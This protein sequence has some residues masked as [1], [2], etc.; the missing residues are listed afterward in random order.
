MEEGNR[1]DGS[2]NKE[3]VFSKQLVA[4]VGCDG[5]Q[6]MG[7]PTCDRIGT[8][9]IPWLRLSTGLHPDQILELQR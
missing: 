9:P 8:L 5:E 1:P 2:E 6:T 4:V 3:T 7:M